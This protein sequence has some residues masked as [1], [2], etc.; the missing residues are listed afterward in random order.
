MATQTI[1]KGEKVNASK[2]K[3][4]YFFMTVLIMILIAAIY[5]TSSDT[6]GKVPTGYASLV[7]LTIEETVQQANFEFAI[8]KEIPFVPT[9]E[10]GTIAITKYGAEEVHRV[11]LHYFNENTSQEVYFIF[12]KREDDLQEYETLAFEEVQLTNGQNAKYGIIEYGEGLTW[13]KGEVSYGI[14]NHIQKGQPTLGLEEMVKLA[15]SISEK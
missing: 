5:F 11:S 12:S 9:L 3:V 2:G 1:T 10:E 13:N 8:P 15:Q 7:G 14:Y 6:G 4:E